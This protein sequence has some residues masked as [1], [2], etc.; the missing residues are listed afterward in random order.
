M[1]LAILKFIVY[2]LGL[3]LVFMLVAIGYLVATKVKKDTSVFSTTEETQNTQ[4]SK[5]QALFWP[6]E[7]LDEKK[8]VIMLNEG[9]FMLTHP[10]CS[11]Y[12]IYDMQGNFINRIKLT[13]ENND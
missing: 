6:K 11:F 10:A 8:Q 5:K 13:G 9:S 2:F 4:P 7:C 1:K 3:L 12:D